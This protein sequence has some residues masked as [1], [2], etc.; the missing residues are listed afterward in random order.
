MSVGGVTRGINIALSLATQGFNAGLN[1][2]S[3]ALRG[4]ARDADGHLSTVAKL[5]RTRMAYLERRALAGR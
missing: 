4:F 5:R 1:S 2:A 3:G